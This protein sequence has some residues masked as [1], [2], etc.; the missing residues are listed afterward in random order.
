MCVCVYSRHPNELELMCV[1]VYCR[2]PKIVEYYEACVDQAMVDALG[3]EPLRDYWASLS[4]RPAGASSD[5]MRGV[6]T[7][8]ALQLPALFSFGAA[9]DAMDPSVVI[10]EFDQGGL[11]LPDAALYAPSDAPGR[12]LLADYAAHVRAMFALAQDPDPDARAQEVRYAP[13]RARTPVLC[14]CEC[15]RVRVT[16]VSVIMWSCDPVHVTCE[17]DHVHVTCVSVITWSCVSGA[18]HVCEYGRVHCV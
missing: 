5:F 1:C 7:L 8:H 15:D 12:R 16:C 14:L 11:T 10:G 6:G 2:Y 9:P 3:L 13:A 17:C 4:V 18:H